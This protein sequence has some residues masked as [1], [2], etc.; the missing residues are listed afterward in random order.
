MSL[1]HDMVG[2]CLMDDEH[3]LLATLYLCC[4]KIVKSSRH[5]NYNF[6][7]EISLR[8]LLFRDAHAKL[9]IKR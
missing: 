4:A 9:Q 2:I 1:C 5:A 8:I 7:Y 3:W 6:V